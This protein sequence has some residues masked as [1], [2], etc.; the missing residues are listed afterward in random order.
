[1][2]RDGE[3]VKFTET[4]ETSG[5]YEINYTDEAGNTSSYAFTVR[6]F[7]NTNAWFVVVLAAAIVLAVGIF[8]I[9]TRT[10][11]RVR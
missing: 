8:M 9:Y 11:M 6:P 10:H 2:T 5:F 3:E 4:I 1:M 7:L